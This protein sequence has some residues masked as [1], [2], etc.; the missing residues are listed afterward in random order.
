[1]A[2]SSQSIWSLKLPATGEV[3]WSGSTQ[4]TSQQLN[5]FLKRI[6]EDTQGD[7]ILT[8]LTVQALRSAPAKS[9]G[10]ILSHFACQFW[11]NE[12]NDIEA[13]KLLHLPTALNKAVCGHVFVRGDLVWSCRTCGKGK[14][15]TS[16]LLHKK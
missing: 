14:V 2:S 1:M 4:P 11:R 6:P 5:E 13:S 15:S 7:E 8:D 3:L 12:R 16:L 10:M 9:V